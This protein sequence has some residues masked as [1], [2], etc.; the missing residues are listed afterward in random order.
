ME[1]KRMSEQSPYEQL[2]V[3]EESSF[4]EI[5]A[6]RD[7]L[8]E[9][10]SSDDKCRSRAEAAYD[11]ILMDRLRRRQQGKIK[12]PEVIRYA[13]RRAAPPPDLSVP[14]MRQS[15]PWLQRL[16]DT[17]SRRDLLLPAALFASLGGLS[18][19]WQSADASALLLALGVGFNLYCL[20]RKERK[21]GRAALLTLAG[22]LLGVVLGTVLQAYIPV[23]L[24]APETLISLTVFLVF[25]LVS[26]FL[27]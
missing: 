21:L 3:S 22:L 4:E 19:Y 6:A 14:R 15:P 20:N 1:E 13:E 10:H 16:I 24:L 26:S 17:P 25:W 8:V 9:V 5:Q 27:R 18:F 23:V 12:V 11:A 7:R 2:G